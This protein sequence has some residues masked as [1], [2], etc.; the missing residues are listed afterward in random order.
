MFGIYRLALAILVLV[1]HLGSVEVFGGLAVWAFFL[2][3]GFLITGVLN[4]RYGYST[5][6]LFEFACGRILRLYPTFWLSVVITLIVIDALSGVLTPTSINSSLSEPGSVRERVA[7]F[8]ML[9]NSWFGLGR[10]ELSPS[11]SAWAVEVEMML[12]VVS[13]FWLS[14]SPLSALKGTLGCLA[15]F[16][17]LWLIGKML[18]RAGWPD[19]P[20]QLTYSFLPAALLPYAVGT[21]L[22]HHRER[23]RWV[24]AT[25]RSIIVGAALVAICGLVVSRFSLTSA[26]ILSLPVFAFLTMALANERAAHHVRKRDDLLGHMSYPIYLMHWLCAYVLAAAATHWKVGGIYV[27]GPH[28]L[29]VFTP[30]GFVCATVFTMLVC[31]LVAVMFEAPIE[32]RRRAIAAQCRR[33]LGGQRASGNA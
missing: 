2:L 12:Y 9:G 27:Q 4:T 30:L 13:A 5:A 3:S 29:L 7:A 10:V 6:G 15:L 16:P 28:G 25:S 24:R 11:P 18:L 1:T 26:Y 23:F 22:W 17:I 21:V 8:T 31:A 19:L 33:W 14:R 20:G 32:R